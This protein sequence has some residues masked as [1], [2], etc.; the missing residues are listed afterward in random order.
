MQKEDD[1]VKQQSPY[2][3]DL[4]YLKTIALL[5]QPFDTTWKGILKVLFGFQRIVKGDDGTIA[6][7][8]LQFTKHLLSIETLAIVAGNKVPH[9]NAIMAAQHMIRAISQPSMGWT[10][11]ITLTTFG[12]SSK[13]QESSRKTSTSASLTTL[14]L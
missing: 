7:I 12:G 14:N 10:K 11:K 2:L 13:K 4:Q 5:Q 6:Y 1:G 3:P 8:V 9:D